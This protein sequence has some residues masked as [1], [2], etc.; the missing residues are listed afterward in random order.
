MRAKN[1]ESWMNR[2]SVI[3]ALGF[4]AA[5]AGCASGSMQT[6]ASPAPLSA[7]AAMLICDSAAPGCTGLTSFS[8]SKVRDLSVTV[9]WKNVPTGTHTQRLDLFLPNGDLYQTFS[10]GFVQP[11][12]LS[13]QLEVKQQIPVMGTWITQRELTGK[14]SVSLSLDGQNLSVGPLDF[15]P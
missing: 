4:S 10:S 9:V 13:S 8:I 6:P 3:A 11:A 5:L 15:Q 12:G 7:S 14:W 2:P 1:K